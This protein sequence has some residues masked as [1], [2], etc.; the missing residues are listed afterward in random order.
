[1]KQSTLEDKLIILA[2]RENKNFSNKLKINEEYEILGIKV[3]LL[4]Q[5]AKEISNEEGLNH[6]KDFL[7]YK[8]AFYYEELIITYFVFSNLFNKMDR[9][10]AFSTLDRLLYYNNSW[11]TNDLIS[12]SIKPKKNIFAP[13]FDYIVGKIKSKNPW[14]IR[15]AIISLMSNY[16]DDEHIDM[17]LLLFSKV[18]N[19][20][21]YVEM[22]IGWA[23]ATALAKQRDKTYPYIF[24]KKIKNSVNKIAIQKAIE[25][26]RISESDKIA[27]KKLRG[28]LKKN[29]A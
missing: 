12:L 22:A 3:P 14:D 8:N 15:F 24:N 5:L 11:A 26:R 4:K 29:K 21:Y 19:S 25:S 28:E 9:D 27:L 18:E 7:N 17:T 10:N 6:V 13:Y 2:D 16:L 20:S 23:F 1:M